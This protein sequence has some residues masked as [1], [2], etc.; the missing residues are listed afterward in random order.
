MVIGVELKI[1]IKNYSLNYIAK[2][3][4]KLISVSTFWGQLGSYISVVAKLVPIIFN[5]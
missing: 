1:S 4:K 5:L 2:K 3:K